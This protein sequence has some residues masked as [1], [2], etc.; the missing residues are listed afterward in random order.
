MSDLLSLDEAADRLGVHYMTAYRY[1]RTGRLPAEKVGA[2]W[3]VRPEDLERFRS[4]EPAAASGRRR[5]DYGRRLEDR[6]ICGDEAGAWTVVQAALTAGID[7]DEL[8]LEVL[9]PAMASI[10]DAWAAGRVSVAQEHQASV[11]A[12]RLVGRLGPLFARRGRKRGTVVLG[13]PPGDHHGLPSALLADL[14]RGDGFAVIDLGADTPEWSFVETAGA[15][16][17]LVAV[18]LSVT[19]E[20]NEDS[21]RRTVDMLRGRVAVPIVVGGGAVRSAEQALRLGADHWSGSATEARA[22]FGRLADEAGR[23]RR[24]TGR[25]ASA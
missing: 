8:Y 13:A 5:A 3:R 19:T 15:A 11:V 20:G 17:R 7:P 23:V 1:V 16:D 4:P 2:T 18:G 25:A 9:G 21:V 6:L 22:L 24:R 14:L 12:Q 10:G